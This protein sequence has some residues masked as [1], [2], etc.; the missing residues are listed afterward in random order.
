MSTRHLRFLAAVVVTAGSLALVPLAAADSVRLWQHTGYGGDSFTPSNAERDFRKIDCWLW[1]C[2]NWNDRVSALHV[3]VYTCVRLFEH[4]SQEGEHVDFCGD[5]EI[6]PEAAA[7][8]YPYIRD[9]PRA[10]AAM[11]TPEDGRRQA[12]SCGSF[13]TRPL[14]RGTSSTTEAPIACGPRRGRQSRDVT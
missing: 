12:S 7:R 13:G 10:V 11:D 6:S 1:F 14:P 5:T 2:D 4:I 8:N 9:P 3:P